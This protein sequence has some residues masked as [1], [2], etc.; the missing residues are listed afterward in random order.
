MAARSRRRES[1]HA[2]PPPPPVEPD[3]VQ[4][5]FQLPKF[6]LRVLDNEAEFLGRM[7]RSVFLELLVLR[8]AG[9]CKFERV[10]TQK[11]GPEAGELEE[12]ERYLWHCRIEI[13]RLL[14]GLRARLGNLPPRS[15]VV[16]ALNEWIGLP[17]GVSDL[18]PIEAAALEEAP[19]ELY[20]ERK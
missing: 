5:A 10:A 12:L 9:L 11:Y 1:H 17:G 13:K 4:V 8:K 16:L 7:R 2:E 15:W 20:P 19:T 14:D 3:Y 6:Y 18:D